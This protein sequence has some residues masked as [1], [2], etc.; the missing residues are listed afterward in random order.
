MIHY[1]IVFLQNKL[2][3]LLYPLSMMQM[4]PSEK[5]DQ[6]NQ[7]PAKQELAVNNEFEM[8]NTDIH[9]IYR[10]IFIAEWKS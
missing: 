2:I 7:F 9:G 4:N 10:M 3:H 8:K 1:Y 5:V 6:V